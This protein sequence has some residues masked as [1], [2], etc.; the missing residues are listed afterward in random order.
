[1]IFVN[2][3]SD[4]L[5]VTQLREHWEDT[6]TKVMSRRNQLEELLVDNQ[7]FEEKRREVES[8]LTRWVFPQTPLLPVLNVKDYRFFFQD[9]VMAWPYAAGGQLDRRLGRSDP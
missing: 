9:G 8:W 7:E 5:S 4:S 3:L 1:M 2:K 6:S